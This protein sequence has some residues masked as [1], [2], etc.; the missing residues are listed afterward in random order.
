MLKR[1]G[2]GV[3]TQRLFRTPRFC[4]EVLTSDYGKSRYVNVPKVCKEEREAS[5][6]T[7]KFSRAV[8]TVYQLVA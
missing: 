4:F 5:I 1:L 2:Q 6:V 3:S 7:M 8:R